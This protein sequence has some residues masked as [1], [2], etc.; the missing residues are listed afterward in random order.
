[1]NFNKGGGL[2][3]KGGRVLA[4]LLLFAGPIAADSPYNRGKLGHGTTKQGGGAEGVYVSNAEFK[5]WPVDNYEKA[6]NNVLCPQGFTC[7]PNRSET[8][9]PFYYHHDER[10]DASLCG[11]VPCQPRK[12]FNKKLLTP[13]PD[14]AGCLGLERLG[15]VYLRADT[16]NYL[17]ACEDCGPGKYAYSVGVHVPRG[18]TLSVWRFKP[19]GAYCSLKNVVTGLYMSMCKR[20]R[21]G[22]SNLDSVFL[23]KKRVNKRKRVDLWKVHVGTDK[24][25]MFESVASGKYLARCRG[26]VG[27]TTIADFAFVHVADPNAAYAR[28]VVEKT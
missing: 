25:Y 4:A 1:M 3:R 18:S 24:K 15:N 8:L 22:P 6:N 5:A 7:I 23:W 28:W 26:C 2:F 17:A 21:S 11:G 20:C 19:V 9:T 10:E 14:D 12:K 13:Q 27:K 16:E